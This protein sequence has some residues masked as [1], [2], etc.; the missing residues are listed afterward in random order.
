MGNDQ[1]GASGRGTPSPSSSLT[2]PDHG[3]VTLCDRQLGCET[4]K[5]RIHVT[6]ISVPQSLEK[7]LAENSITTRSIS[8]MEQK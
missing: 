8:M 4:L 7:G 3:Q 5:G 1:T 2:P 6:S